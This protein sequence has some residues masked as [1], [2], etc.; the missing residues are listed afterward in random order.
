MKIIIYDTEIAGFNKDIIQLSYIIVNDKKII[1]KNYYFKADYIYPKA[2]EIHGLSV[3]KLKKLSRGKTFKDYV[4]IIK[5]DFEETDLL[6]AHNYS[7]DFAYL[8]KA[9][10]KCNIEFKDVNKFCTMNYFRSICNIPDKRG[11]NKAP[12]LRELIEFYKR[13]NRYVRT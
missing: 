2:Q 11:R 5:H 3:E 6:I 4:K 8:R 1:P 9:F 10:L 13:Y 12:K 7:F